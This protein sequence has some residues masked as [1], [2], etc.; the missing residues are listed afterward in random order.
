[1]SL[2]ET[3]N[4]DLLNAM[5]AGDEATKRTLRG[6]KTAIT[7]EEK[8][9]DNRPLTDE[10]IIDVLRKQAKQRRESIAAF[11]QGGRPDLAADEKAELAVIEQYLPTLMDEA[12]VRAQAMA[13]IAEVGATGPRD[14][15]K[16]MSKLMPMLKGKADGRLVNEVVKQLLAGA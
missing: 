5:R 4:Q 15:G 2:A 11:E 1:M 13:V 3:L 14:T 6:V 8:E 16:V 10:E 7:R 9:V 12:A